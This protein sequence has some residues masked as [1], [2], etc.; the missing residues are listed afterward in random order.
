M[1]MQGGLEFRKDMLQFRA[2]NDKSLGAQFADS[3]F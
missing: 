1:L 2:P 3:I